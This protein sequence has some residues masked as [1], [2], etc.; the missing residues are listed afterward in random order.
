MRLS[1]IE[2]AQPAAAMPAKNEDSAGHV[3]DRC[4][5]VVE[6]RYAFC[7]HCGNPMKAAGRAGE[8]RAPAPPSPRRLVIDV[9]DASTVDPEREDKPSAVFS[10]G[11]SNKP[12][13]MARGG[14]SALKLM[15]VTIVTGAALLVAMTG[16]FWLRGWASPANS[17]L[18]SQAASANLQSGQTLVPTVEAADK[19]VVEPTQAV[20]VAHP[21]E[22][23]LRKLRLRRVGATTADRPAIWRDFG[24]S[25][26]QYPSDYRFPY[27]R[28]KLALIGPPAK[29]FEAAFQALFLAAEKAIRMGQAQEMLHNLDADKNGDFRKLSHGHPEWSQLVQALK[30]RDLKLLSASNRSRQ[31]E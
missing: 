1:E 17:G 29:S 7:W 31:A 12:K 14:N 10:P 11:L 4:G 15:V 20:P 26:R 19:P 2:R 6:D 21:G 8:K 18:V 5:E 13:K 24:R 22:D 27:E 30:S 23:D 3:C 16:V 9:D 25:E 28:A